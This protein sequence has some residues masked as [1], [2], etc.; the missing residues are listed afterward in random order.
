ML[1]HSNENTDQRA[2]PQAGHALP[3]DPTAPCLIP[4][5]ADHLP[6]AVGF[7]GDTPWSE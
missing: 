5:R 2:L 1:K 3:S 6:H 7:S 4:L